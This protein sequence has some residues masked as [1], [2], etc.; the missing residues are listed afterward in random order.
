MGKSMIFYSVEDYER[1]AILQVE[2][3][4]GL[5]LKQVTEN[6][7]PENAGLAQGYAGVCIASVQTL[8]AEILEVWK[9]IGV[10]SIITRSAGYDH[11]DLGMLKRYGF[12][13]SNISYSP[14][15]VADYTI[16]LILMVTRNIK[17]IQKMAEV[18][19]Y[20]FI[21]TPG[22][23]LWNMTVGIIGT[24]AIG[25]TV[26]RHLSAFGCKILMYSRH[27]KKELELYAR[28]ASLEELLERS[29]LVSLHVAANADTF[30]LI[31]RDTLA[32]MKKDAFIVNT[33]R[34]TLVDT[35]ALI[36]A[37]E[38]GR[39]GGAALD[40]IEGEENFYYSDCRDTLMDSHELAILQHMPNVIL[41]PHMAFYTEE[42]IY[43]MVAN[44]VRNL[45]CV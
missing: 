1:A 27:H 3:E 22:K 35:K 10:R 24:G 7:N 39:L 16:M 30:H 17:K 31:N 41:T 44:S 5:V 13:F 4:S 14:S 15:S 32:A 29:D 11:M 25:S 9:K 33:G 23:E 37:L 12:Q 26:I 42:A 19:D 34:G 38:N 18:R 21:K 43:D 40:V 45:E 28:Q 36:E 6:A 2:K 8:T 20:S